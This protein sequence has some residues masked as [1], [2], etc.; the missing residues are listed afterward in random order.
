MLINIMICSFTSSFY[1]GSILVKSF[2]IVDLAQDTNIILMILFS[3]FFSL[4]IGL[5]HQSYQ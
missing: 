4:I 2:G 5:I 1:I 3:I